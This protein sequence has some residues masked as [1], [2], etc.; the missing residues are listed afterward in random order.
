MKNLTFL[1]HVRNAGFAQNPNSDVTI[2]DDS[3]LPRDDSSSSQ[4]VGKAELL[5]I[6]CP[7]A[8]TWKQEMDLEDKKKTQNGTFLLTEYKQESKQ[9]CEPNA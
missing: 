6:H 4:P 8:K 7:P 5:Q 2:W 3:P 1:D 9:K